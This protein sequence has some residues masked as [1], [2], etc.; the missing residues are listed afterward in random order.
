[1]IV[2]ELESGDL[3]EL[4]GLYA[5]LHDSDSPLPPADEVDA[6]WRELLASSRYRYVGATVDGHLVSSC[7]LTV[8]P[9]L[10]RG[11]RPFGVIENVVTHSGF[12]GRGLGRAVLARALELAWAQDCYKVMLLTGRKDEAIIRFYEGAGF[13]REGKQ[14]FVARAPGE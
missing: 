6:V 5:H 2:R 4:L 8:I 1:M 12:R 13:D 7:A 14:G 10:T 9:N 11:C 3:E